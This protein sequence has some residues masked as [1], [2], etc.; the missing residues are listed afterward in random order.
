M[1]VLS[2]IFDQSCR[3]ENSRRGAAQLHTMCR[4]HQQTQDTI[5]QDVLRQMGVTQYRRATEVSSES[6]LP[7]SHWLCWNSAGPVSIMERLQKGDTNLTRNELEPVVELSRLT[8]TASGTFGSLQRQFPQLTDQEVRNVMILTRRHQVHR[9]TNH[10]TN[11]FPPGQKCSQHY[12]Q[13]PSLMCIVSR[14]PKMVTAA[15][16]RGFPAVWRLHQEV[17]ELLRQQPHQEDVGEAEAEDPVPAL[18]DLLRQLGPDPI[19]LPDTITY[20]WAGLKIRHT[21]EL[22]SLLDN[23]AVEQ[24]DTVADQL[25]LGLW[26]L[27]L[28]YRWHPRMVLE[29]RVSEAWVVAYHP[30]LLLAARANVDVS[31]VTHTVPVLVDYMTK[32]ATSQTIGAAASQVERWGGADNLRHAE[33]LRQHAEGKSREVSLTEGL[34]LLDSDLTISKTNCIVEWVSLQPFSVMVQMYIQR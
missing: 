11:S 1:T 31:L 9:C 29:R 28:G 19:L 17:Q 26:H 23:L 7:H 25:L 33:L 18:L 21:A 3:Y 14:R 2:V 5:I 4:Q 24:F 13:L 15:Q 32:G 10:C 34:Y 20:E 27:T 12:P 8:S 22:Q 30:R 16:K 6:G